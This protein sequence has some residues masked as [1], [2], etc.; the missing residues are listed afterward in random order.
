M[1]QGIVSEKIQKTDYIFE[2]ISATTGKLLL[3]K[4]ITLGKSVVPKPVIKS[5]VRGIFERMNFLFFS[6]TD[7]LKNRFAL[8]AA[9]LESN[10]HISILRKGFAFVENEKLSPVTSLKD[11]EK[12]TVMNLVFSDGKLKVKRVPAQIGLF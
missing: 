12:E 4:K 7:F 11:A 8:A 3:Q 6:K 9:S 5:D 10:S 2:K 1:I